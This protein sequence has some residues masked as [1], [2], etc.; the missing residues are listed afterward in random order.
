MEGTRID[1]GHMYDSHT[2]SS[3][4]KTAALVVSTGYAAAVH[5][6]YAGRRLAVEYKRPGSGP[7][8]IEAKLFRNQFAY[9]NR[10]V[11]GVANA[12][13]KT[14]GRLFR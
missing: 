3:T 1:S 12:L 4:E 7:K 14:F 2:V 5:E 11:E 9:R 13:R 8:C 6:G 10:I